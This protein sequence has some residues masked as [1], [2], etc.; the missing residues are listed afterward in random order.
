MSIQSLAVLVDG[1]NISPDYAEEILQKASPL[2]DVSIRLVFGDFHRRNTPPWNTLSVKALGY[3]LMYVSRAYRG[4]NSADKAMC[5]RARHLASRQCVKAICIVSCDGDFALLAEE[6]ISAGVPCYAMGPNHTSARLI[7]HCQ[8]FIR[9]GEH[10]DVERPTS[11]HRSQIHLLR[12]A[13]ATHANKCGWAKLQAVDRYLRRH[14]AAYRENR[15][16]FASISKIVMAAGHFEIQD[17]PDNQ[18]RVRS[19]D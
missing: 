5:S 14:S 9:L 8:R 10:H 2:G 1:E 13:V 17:F 11:H 15:W 19:S 12:H 4:S 18:R 6:L 3:K 7:S 16:G